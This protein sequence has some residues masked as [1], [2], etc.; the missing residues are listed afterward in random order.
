MFNIKG[1]TIRIPG[2]FNDAFLYGDKLFLLDD[3]YLSVIDF[4]KLILN[5]VPTDPEIKALC[6]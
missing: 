5:I 3:K 2:Q 1:L 4:V 6:K